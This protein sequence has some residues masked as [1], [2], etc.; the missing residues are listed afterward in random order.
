MLGQPHRGMHA[1]TQRALEKGVLL[2]LD[3]LVV[4]PACVVDED[5]H[6]TEVGD[7]QLHQCLTLRFVIELTDMPDHFIAFA[8][9]CLERGVDGL[10]VLPLA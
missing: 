10:G 2:A 4:H 3:A 6:G 5:V 1:D 9:Q 8:L 7:R